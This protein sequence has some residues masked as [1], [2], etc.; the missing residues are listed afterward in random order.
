M[1]LPVRFGMCL[2][3]SQHHRSRTTREADRWVCP[4]LPVAVACPTGCR[5]VT[6]V[7]TFGDPLDTVEDFVVGRGGQLAAALAVSAALVGAVREQCGHRPR[8][9]QVRTLG[10]FMGRPHGR[11]A[12]QM[13]KGH[14]LGKGLRPL[15]PAISL[16]VATPSS[17]GRSSFSAPTNFCSRSRNVRRAV[18][19][20]VND[21]FGFPTGLYR[22]GVNRLKFLVFCIKAIKVRF[23][24]L[25]PNK[26]DLSLPALAQG[27]FG[28]SAF[29]IDFRSSIHP[30]IFP[31]MRGL[32][33]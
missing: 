24:R 6:S 5:V 29:A 32:D 26:K 1:Q 20:S 23:R 12:G 8:P 25:V 33:V 13:K 18:T 22:S 17:E 9:P 7:T 15:K 2:V 11:S 28:D 21:S 4:L 19:N 30:K 27:P 14:I 31:S 10:R 16:S 3:R